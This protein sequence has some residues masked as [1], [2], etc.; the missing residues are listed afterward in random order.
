MK[1]KILAISGKPGLYKL[2]SQGRNMFIV[3]DLVNHKNVPAFAKDRLVSLED[4]AIYTEDEEVPL[5]DVFMQIK[6]KE[7]GGEAKV[8]VSDDAAMATY[9]GEVLPKYDRDRVHKSDIKKVFKWYNI[10]INAGINDF[11]K[12]E[13]KA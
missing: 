7:N 8:D 10:L 12:E 11:E 4:I 2:V 1:D 6:Q 9:F 5:V 3:E 13:A